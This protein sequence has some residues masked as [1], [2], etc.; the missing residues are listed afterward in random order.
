MNGACD[1]KPEERG[2]KAADCCALQPIRE[3]CP[4]P[5]SRIERCES[6]QQ[7]ENRTIQDGPYAKH[8]LVQL[9]GAAFARPSLGGLACYGTRRM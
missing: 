7:R 1:K 9:K 6:G 4:H 8:R 2:D 5:Y 3:S